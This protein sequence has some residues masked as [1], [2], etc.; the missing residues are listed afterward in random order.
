[1]NK[2]GLFGR[3]KKGFKN[4]KAEVES[5]KDLKV[6]K[7]ELSEPEIEELPPTPT[8]E[9]EDIVPKRGRPKKVVEQQI[10]EP[11][12]LEEEEGDDEEEELKKKLKQVQEEKEAKKLLEEQSQPKVFIK[13]VVVPVEDMFNELSD[14]LENLEL[15]L[16]QTI[17]YLKSR[18]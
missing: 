16:H 13:K 6:K 14:R 3:N 15:T 7:E 10:P 8:P 18:Q 12:E 5:L 17:S 2:R 9:D 11:P 1:M 4:A